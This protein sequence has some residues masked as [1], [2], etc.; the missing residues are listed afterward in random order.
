MPNYNSPAIGAGLDFSGIFTF[1]KANI[2][3]SVPWDIGAYK[4]IKVPMAPGNL[5]V[6]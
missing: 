2:L 1:D 3:R 5:S 6:N 4:Y